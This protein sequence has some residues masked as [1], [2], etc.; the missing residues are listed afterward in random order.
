MRKFVG[1]V[2]LG[3]YVAALGGVLLLGV[4][5]AAGAAL[6]PHRM[7]LLLLSGLLARSGWLYLQGTARG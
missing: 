3:Y 1:Y 2:L 5:A 7:G 6:Q 4:A